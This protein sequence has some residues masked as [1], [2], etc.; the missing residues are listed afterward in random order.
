M[1]FTGFENKTPNMEMAIESIALGGLGNTR[2]HY[3]GKLLNLDRGILVQA[4]D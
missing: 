2:V 1:C 3:G 4:S